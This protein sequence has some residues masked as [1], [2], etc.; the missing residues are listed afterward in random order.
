MERLNLTECEL[1][2]AICNPE[3]PERSKLAT[4]EI[5]RTL[6]ELVDKVN[7]LESV[8]RHLHRPSMEIGPF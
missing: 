8:T 4:K 1:H 7:R 3:V 2:T 5:V 6:N